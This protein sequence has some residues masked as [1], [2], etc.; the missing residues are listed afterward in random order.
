LKFRGISPKQI[1]S[2]KMM[3]RV[4]RPV[5][6]K[7]NI[8]CWEGEGSTL[9]FPLSQPNLS[10][11]RWSAE[12]DLW[13]PVWWAAIGGFCYRK[14]LENEC[15]RSF[16]RVVGG[17][18]PGGWAVMVNEL[19]LWIASAKHVCIARGAWRNTIN[20]GGIRN[21]YK[22]LR[23]RSLPKLGPEMYLNCSP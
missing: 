11:K 18:G 10:T 5:I 21:S 23:G 20:V 16:S 3:I 22:R 17:G 7:E 8:L 12:H 2:L 9:T 19:L 6:W 4:C 1:C 13:Q 14:M 15:E